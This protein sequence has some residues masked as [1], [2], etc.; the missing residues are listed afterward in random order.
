MKREPSKRD[1]QSLAIVAPKLGNICELRLMTEGGGTI[2]HIA[3]D[4]GME[5]ENSLDAARRKLLNDQSIWE[6]IGR[7]GLVI[8]E[9]RR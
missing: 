3:I 2:T 9:V 8:K 7:T 5:Y 6:R 1:D 4:G